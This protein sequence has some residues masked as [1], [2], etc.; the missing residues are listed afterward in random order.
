MLRMGAIEEIQE[1]DLVLSSVYTVPKKN[2]KRRMVINL[3]WVNE[4][5]NK[6]H[7]KT[8]TMKDVKHA[9]TKDCWMASIDLADCFWALRVAESDQRALAFEFNGKIYKF[10]VLPFGLGPSPMFITKL[11]RKVVEDL[12]A[13]G[14]RVMIY[15]DD[16]LVLGA[17][18]AECE[19][20]AS[21]VARLLKLLGAVINDAKSTMTAAQ[22]VDYLGF[23]LDSTTMTVT[24]PPT[25]M[26]NLVKA[27]KKGA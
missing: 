3:R 15:I 23:T 13:R 22:V 27:L 11:Y 24:A 19:A 6:V 21:E 2:G 26:V 16:I 12:Q 4:H 17:T 1:K 9:L 14:H 8:S 10:K 18:K 20:S 25:K 7:F 5:L